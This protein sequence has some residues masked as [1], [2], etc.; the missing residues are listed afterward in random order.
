M[1]TY[2]IRGADAVQA[3]HPLGQLRGEELRRSGRGLP[4]VDVRGPLPL[5]VDGEELQPKLRHPLEGRAGLLGNADDA[6]AVELVAEVEDYEH[7][8]HGHLLDEVTRSYAYVS[9]RA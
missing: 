8:D 4:H 2:S 5:L 6:L 1:S 7:A 3:R 9:R